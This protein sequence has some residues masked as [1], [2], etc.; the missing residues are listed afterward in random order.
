ML[1]SPIRISLAAAVT[2]TVQIS[3]LA[4]VGVTLLDTHVVRLVK[5]VR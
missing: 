5:V 3:V 4:L 1:P 2:T